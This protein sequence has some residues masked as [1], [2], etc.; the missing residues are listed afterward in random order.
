ML[1]L[2]CVQVCKL[3]TMNLIEGGGPKKKKKKNQLSNVHKQKICKLA[4]K[5]EKFN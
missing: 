5:T 2:L 3:T 1:M 4:K